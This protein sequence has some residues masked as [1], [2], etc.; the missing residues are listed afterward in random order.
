[1]IYIITELNYLKYF[2]NL[3]KEISNFSNIYLQIQVMIFLSLKNLYF[4][5]IINITIIIS[6]SL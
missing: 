6:I 3:S 5:Q 4:S 1:M 2:E